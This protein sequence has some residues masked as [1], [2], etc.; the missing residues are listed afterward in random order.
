[1]V[2]TP[3]TEDVDYCAS[4]TLPFEYCYKTEKCIVYWKTIF[5]DVD[6][7]AL[8]QDYKKP[9]KIKTESAKTGGKVDIVVSSRGGKKRVTTVNGLDQFD[10]PLKPLAKDWSKQFACACSAS[11]EQIVIQ[12]DFSAELPDL[13]TK[14]F[15]NMT[16]VVTKQDKKKKS[17]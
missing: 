11:K 13:L 10:I 15:E 16:V 14:Q 6:E 8:K 4:C 7:D 3:R 5:P 12:G 1:M 9:K 17:S 2:V